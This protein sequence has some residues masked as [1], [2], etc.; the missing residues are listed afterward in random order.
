M[1]LK[2]H[3]LNGIKALELGK[4]RFLPAGKG[5]AS[6]ST[7]MLSAADDKPLEGTAGTR[8]PA[9]LITAEGKT[10]LDPVSLLPARP[11]LGEAQ[12][13]PFVVKG[14]GLAV[15]STLP[16]APTGS[17]SQVSVLAAKGYRFPSD[18]AYHVALRNADEPAEIRLVPAPRIRVMG[19]NQKAT[20]T[21]VPSDLLGGRASGRLELQLQDDHAGPSDWL[22][23]PATFLDLPV[24]VGVQEAAPGV[25][26]IGPSLDPIEAVAPGPDGPWEKPSVQVE[27]GHE[28]MTLTTSLPG[29]TCYL[30][31]FGWPALVLAVHLPAPLTP[32][33][34]PAPIASATPKP[35]EPAPGSTAPSPAPMPVAPKAAAAKPVE[36]A[37]A[38]QPRKP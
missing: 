11:R 21:F 12:V 6:K 15:T 29:S 1:V 20:F 25:R 27:E 3:H 8:L 24:I 26:L 22:P 38:T 7:L 30:R 18:G 16:V 36:P 9:I 28:A 13:V 5:A 14:A 2:G 37:S 35:E 4:R 10:E 33:K 17:P 19:N 23:L 32:P 31:V 34:P